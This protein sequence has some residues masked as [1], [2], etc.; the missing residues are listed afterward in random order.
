VTTIVTYYRYEVP[1]DG[2][3]LGYYALEEGQGI[4][5]KDVSGVSH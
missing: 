3:L 5:A 2:G 4:R 1:E